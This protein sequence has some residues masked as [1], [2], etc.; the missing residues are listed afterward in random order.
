MATDATSLYVVTCVLLPWGELRPHLVSSFA[1]VTAA[2]GA[3]RARGEAVAAAL[4]AHPRR[5][6]ARVDVCAVPL[7]DVRSALPRSDADGPAADA[8]GLYVCAATLVSQT[9]TSLDIDGFTHV[10]VAASEREARG[11]AQ[12]AASRARPS[13]WMGGLAV[14]RVPPALLASVLADSPVPAAGIEDRLRSAVARAERI[15]RAEPGGLPAV[16]LSERL[17]ASFPGGMPVEEANRAIH[18][19][20]DR[21]IAAT[22]AGFRLALVHGPDRAAAEPA[23]AVRT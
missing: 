11:D 2:R 13:S 17:A 14:Q 16:V 12:L 23:A 20:L 5:A 7:A 10:L 3:A 18:R 6:V 1:H 9:A 8:H 22:G 4:D 15:L 19:L 21:G